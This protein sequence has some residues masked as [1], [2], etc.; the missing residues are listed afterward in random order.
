V[1]RPPA[2]L[3]RYGLS[4]WRRFASAQAARR[5]RRRAHRAG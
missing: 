5:W 2:T 1:T 3:K 4:Y